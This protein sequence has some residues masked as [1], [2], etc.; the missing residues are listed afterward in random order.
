[1]KYNHLEISAVVE[2]LKK[3]LDIHFAK[4]AICEINDGIVIIYPII[5]LKKEIAYEIYFTRS[6]AS[7]KKGSSSVE[8]FEGLLTEMAFI[9][10]G[11]IFIVNIVS[12][13]VGYFIFFDEN[14]KIFSILKSNEQNFNKA[15]SLEKHYITIGI[16]NEIT[17][18][19]K[20]K[21]NPIENY[22]NNA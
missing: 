19:N 18:Y 5:S 12:A 17:I 15:I 3:G 16:N 2:M 20:R 14:Y 6:T 13:A 8:G 9:K 10:E 11:E 7:K 1:M 21:I 22:I 4:E